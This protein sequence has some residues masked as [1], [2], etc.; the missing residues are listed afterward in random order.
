MQGAERS[1]Q[2]NREAKERYFKKKLAEAKEIKCACGCGNTLLEYDNFA[3][4]RT[5]ISGH[6][7]RKYEDPTQFKR[8]WNH[9]NRKQRYEYKQRWLKKRKIEL[10]LSHG[11]KCL[12]CGY[13][14]EE[15]GSNA[16][17]FDFHHRDPNKKEFNIRLNSQS[18]D[19]INEEL[20]KCDLLCAVCHRL[21]H[22]RHK[23]E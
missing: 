21:V 16:S 20:K 9:R 8:E 22:H 6:N 1:K 4:K 5:F 23:N 19:R 2:L 7:G 3:R 14:L 15:D 13:A 17:A 12:Q 10:V 18:I 11:G